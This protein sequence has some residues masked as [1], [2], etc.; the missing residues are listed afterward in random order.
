[1]NPNIPFKFKTKPEPYQPVGFPK[2]K[3][4]SLPSIKIKKAPKLPVLQ[5]VANLKKFIE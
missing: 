5:S 1:M 3:M 2:V 4:P